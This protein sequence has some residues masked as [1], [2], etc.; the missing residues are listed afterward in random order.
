MDGEGHRGQL[1]SL[2][3]RCADDLIQT[4]G[5]LDVQVVDINDNPPQFIDTENSISISEVYGT[6]DYVYI[7][8]N[9]VNYFFLKE[10]NSESSNINGDNF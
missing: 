9:A 10:C 5:N 4:F 3:F 2:T 7:A 8:L 6:I 1:F